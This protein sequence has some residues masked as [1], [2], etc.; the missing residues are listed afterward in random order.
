MESLKHLPL[1][2]LYVLVLSGAFWSAGTKGWHQE[3]WVLEKEL[4]R[5]D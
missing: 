2:L 1:C 5:I 3:S 4:C